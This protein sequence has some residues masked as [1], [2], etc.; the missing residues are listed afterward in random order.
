MQTSTHNA[1]NVTIVAN[2]SDIVVNDCNDI[3]QAYGY[4]GFII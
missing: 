2:G 3:V 4:A 1:F